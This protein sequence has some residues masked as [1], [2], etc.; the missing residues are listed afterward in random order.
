MAMVAF[1]IIC[2]AVMWFHLDRVN[3]RREKGEEEHSI[4]GMR[5]EEVAELGDDS[6]RFKYTI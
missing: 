4:A 5:D 2:Y 3:K 6:P 1:A